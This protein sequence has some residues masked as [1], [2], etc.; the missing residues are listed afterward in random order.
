M[1]HTSCLGALGPAQAG[2]TAGAGRQLPHRTDPSP[3]HWP[4]QAAGQM[5]QQTGRL[6]GA[7]GGGGCREHFRVGL[8]TCVSLNIAQGWGPGD[9]AG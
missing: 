5:S 8:V 1:P 6:G 3:W 9:Q 4:G 7:V 2:G